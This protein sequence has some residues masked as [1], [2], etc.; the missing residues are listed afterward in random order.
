[1][2]TLN[3]TASNFT[4]T[5]NSTSSFNSSSIQG[6]NMTSI[7]CQT[8]VTAF[9]ACAENV[10]SGN[11]T[12]QETC[13]N[14]TSQY[15]DLVAQC[16]DDD[17]EKSSFLLGLSLNCHKENDQYCQGTEEE[18]CGPCR[19]YTSERIYTTGHIDSLEGDNKMKV[20]QCANGSGSIR[21]VVIVG[22]S[23]LSLV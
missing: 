22:L 1:M 19:K 8:T 11:S 17:Y 23:L 16:N 9:M 10:P 13:D 14:C 18:S 2:S 4:N 7:I 15:N 20:M 3:S 6:L 5:D 12:Y 21:A